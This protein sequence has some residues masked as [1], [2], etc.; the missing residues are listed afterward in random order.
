M[1]DA[2]SHDVGKDEAIDKEVVRFSAVRLPDNAGE[3][4]GFNGKTFLGREMFEEAAGGIAD[5]EAFNRFIGDAPLIE[6]GAGL[7]GEA[8]M[9]V[10][11][12]CGEDFLHVA[13]FLR[14]EKLIVA[15]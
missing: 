14:M 8:R 4:A 11:G 13:D 3:K 1:D 9:V 5:L 10:I 7:G 6:P 15:D 12:G 2:A